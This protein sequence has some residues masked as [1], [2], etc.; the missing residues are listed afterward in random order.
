[1]TTAIPKFTATYRGKLRVEKGEEFKIYMKSFKHEKFWIAMGKY[2]KTKSRQAEKY[3]W[4]GVLPPIMEYT[5]HTAEELHEI[6][7]RKFII[8]KI[9]KW[10]G[11]HIK[12]VGST[13][14]MF[15]DEQSEFITKVIREAADM[16][17]HILTPQEYY[18][19]E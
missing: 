11:V 12:L 19:G 10:R 1:M 13:K 4:G 2:R 7:K 14:D 15:R 9:V 16:G 3:Y 18:L 8:P 6:F 17:I 5:G